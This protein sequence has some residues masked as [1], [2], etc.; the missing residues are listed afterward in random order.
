ML[1]TLNPSQKPSSVNREPCT[2]PTPKTLGRKSSTVNCEPQALNPQSKALNPEFTRRLG[3]SRAG[4][5]CATFFVSLGRPVPMNPAAPR[6]RGQRNFEGCA[7]SRP[8]ERKHGLST[9]QVPVSAYVGSSKN[10]KD[11]KG[12]HVAPFHQS[13][14]SA[15]VLCDH[16]HT[17]LASL[18]RAV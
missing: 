12:P 14:L 3:F 17:A 16:Q 5:W 15:S 10:L 6:E 13:G 8:S 1:S 7:A 2:H 4:N 11:L 9:K 18:E